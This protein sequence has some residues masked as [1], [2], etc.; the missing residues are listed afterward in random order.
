MTGLC[1][2]PRARVAGLGVMLALALGALLGLTHPATASAASSPR[3]CFYTEDRDIIH[4]S[5]SGHAFLQLLPTTGSQ[6]GSRELVYGF[7]PKK[8]GEGLTESD[9]AVTSNATHKWHW[10]ICKTVAARRYESARQLLAADIAKPPR[11]ALLKFN[12]TDWIYK[13]AARAG[14]TLPSAKA[15]WGFT[16]IFDPQ[17]LGNKLKAEWESQGSR[18]F[19]GT[20][21]PFKN[22][23]NV[24]PNNAAD[25]PTPRIDLSSVTDLALE[26]FSAP[27]VLARGLDMAD[28]S[29]TLPEAIV[30]S[31]REV[32][33]SLSGIDI[34]GSVTEVKFGDGSQERQRVSFTHAYPHPGHY[35]VLGIVLAHSTVF[36]FGFTV[37]VEHAGGG[38]SVHVAVPNDPRPPDHLPPL[39][40]AIVPLS[41]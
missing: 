30:G 25:P 23:N 41:E 13:I 38:T 20:N 29:R 19:P 2:Y 40:P 1:G 32:L 4:G 34:H 10:K 24:N 12:C 21:K 26:A 15:A 14:V 33:L 11:Y 22:V 8:D 6:A 28:A 35:H 7:A 37:V 9:G 18:N 31:G 39:K 3:I 17:A 5:K 36:H 27:G 16:T